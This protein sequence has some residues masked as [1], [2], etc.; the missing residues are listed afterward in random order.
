MYLKIRPYFKMQYVSYV[1]AYTNNL[2]HMIG[3]QKKLNLQYIS[4]F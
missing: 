1:S 2:K 3:P 4:M